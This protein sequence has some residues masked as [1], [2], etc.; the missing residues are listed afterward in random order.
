M[1]IVILA[2]ALAGMPTCWPAVN[3][4]ALQGVNLT[5]WFIVCVRAVDPGAC[6]T[7]VIRNMQDP[8]VVTPVS[9][10]AAVVMRKAG[11]VD[12]S[13]NASV[14]VPVRPNSGRPPGDVNGILANAATVAEV[15]GT[16]RLA[17]ATCRG[18]L[19]LP[20]PPQAESKAAKASALAVQVSLRVLGMAGFLACGGRGCWATIK[21]ASLLISLLLVK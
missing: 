18:G 13:V 9:V 5:V 17:L 11:D 3:K 19:A 1:P 8:K 10:P 20:P 15:T 12:V 21:N 7:E 14:V 2:D 4:L 6:M 16:V